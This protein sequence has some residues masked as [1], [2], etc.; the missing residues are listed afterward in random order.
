MLSGGAYATVNLGAGTSAQA[1]RP[2][3][4]T[5]DAFLVCTRLEGNAIDEEVHLTSQH[6]VL[7]N[8]TW[9]CMNHPL[10]P[11]SHWTQPTA[12]TKICRCVGQM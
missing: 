5:V 1:D 10:G 4:S 3:S 9:I 8:H 2:R 7:P 12:Y 6:A 11:Y